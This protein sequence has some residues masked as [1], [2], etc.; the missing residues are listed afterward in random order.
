[1]IYLCIFL[2]V[3]SSA[4]LAVSLKGFEPFCRASE[5]LGHAEGG[6]TSQLPEPFPH[7]AAGEGCTGILLTYCDTLLTLNLVIWHSKA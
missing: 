2:C 1:M 3:S 6:D 5:H 7:P 4:L